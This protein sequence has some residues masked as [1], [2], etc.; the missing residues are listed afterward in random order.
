MAGSRRYRV[1]DLVLLGVAVAACLA[2]SQ[3]HSLKQMRL[4][5]YHVTSDCPGAVASGDLTLAPASPSDTSYFYS[6]TMDN[7]TKYGF[8]S[9]TLQDG[10]SSSSDGASAIESSSGSRNCRG[11]SWSEGES[12]LIFICREGEAVVCTIALTAAS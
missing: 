3:M 2:T 11:L 9:N 1:S 6:L 5:N 4:G 8:P 12:N 7:G 10:Y